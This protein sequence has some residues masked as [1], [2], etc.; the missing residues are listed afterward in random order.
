MI[1]DPVAAS[2]RGTERGECFILKVWPATRKYSLSILLLFFPS[3]S[4]PL[5]LSSH[6]PHSAFIYFYFLF[7]LFSIPSFP[8]IFLLYSLFLL[9]PVLTD[10]YSFFP[11]SSFISPHLQSHV[12]SFILSLSEVSRSVMFLSE[13][14]CFFFICLLFLYPFPSQNWGAPVSTWTAKGSSCSRCLCW[15]KP[16]KMPRDMA[17]G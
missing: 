2:P 7:L 9:S 4:S 1:T 11:N 3:F 5:S 12:T 15:V 16:F 6:F 10:Y 13:F 14:Y 17:G 8:L